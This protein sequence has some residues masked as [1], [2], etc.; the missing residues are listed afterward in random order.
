MIDIQSTLADAQVALS[1][2]ATPVIDARL[3]LSHV[4]GVPHSYLLA[5]GEQPLTPA[6]Q[7]H[8]QD[9][10]ARASRQIPIPYLLEQAPFFDLTFYVTPAVLIPRPET[11]E[12]VQFALTWLQRRESVRIVD[13]GTGSGCIAVTLARHLPAGHAI[14]AV[15]ISADALEVARENARR[16]GVSERIQF[17][18]GNLLA[19]LPW[20]PDLI[21]ANLPYVTDTEWTMLSDGVKLYEPPLALIGGVDGLDIVRNLLRQA[22]SRIADGGAILLEI[23]W[24]QGEAARQAALS[25]FPR[26]DVSLRSDLAGHDR[27]LFIQ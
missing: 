10:L 21:I 4:L 2:S 1:H 12:L 8:F 14:A 17:L 13:V 26:G 27:F 24:R 15:D 3:L 16:H 22:S 11:E 20:S 7:A 23:G 9:L 19:P 5:H 25:T 6:Q 18:Q